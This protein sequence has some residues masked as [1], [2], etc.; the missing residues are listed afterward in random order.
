VHRDLFT[1]LRGFNTAFEYGGDYEFFVR[2]L[3]QEHFSRITRVVSCCYRHGENMSMR[4]DD[5][6]AETQMIAEL[7]APR[8]PLRR[9]AYR[10]LLK[11][12]VNATNPWWLTMKVV[13]G[14]VR[15]PGTRT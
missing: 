5:Y 14:T 8:A 12:W 10:F 1:D 7:Y 4:R 11:S 13:R 3:E 6:R 9:Q 15:A 2:A